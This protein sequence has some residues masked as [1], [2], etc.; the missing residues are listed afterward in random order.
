VHLLAFNTFYVLF[1]TCYMFTQRTA[2]STSAS[3]PMCEAHIVSYSAHLCIS[4]WLQ[5]YCK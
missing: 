1:A 2:H 3:P 4:I 5:S